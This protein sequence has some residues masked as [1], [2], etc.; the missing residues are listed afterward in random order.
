MS[1]SL[2]PR[3]SIVT[4][5]V[6]SLDRARRFY[7]DGLRWPL[8]PHSN[9]NIAFIQMPG[10]MLALFARGDLA[11]DAGVTMEAVKVPPVTLA[12]LVRD[13][14]E[15]QPILRLA[16]AAGGRVVM[17]PTQREWG[18]ISGYM[19]DPDGFLWEI[20]FNPFVTLGPD[21]A[22]AAVDGE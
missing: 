5:G 22:M 14:A 19:A 21:G 9:E 10:M 1:E 4:L 13:E 3:L 16:S 20:A 18:G 15:I 8:A 7:V 2:Q 11:A 17:G 6:Q 12:Y